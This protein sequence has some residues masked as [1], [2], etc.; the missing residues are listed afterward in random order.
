MFGRKKGGIE[1]SFVDY[2]KCLSDL[3]CEVI[4][5]SYENTPIIHTLPANIQV[6][7]ITNFGQWDPLAAWKLKKMIR[8]LNPD[9]IIAHANRATNLLHKAGI[10]VPIVGVCHKYS[11]NKMLEC[12]YLITVTKDLKTQM[13]KK[14]RQASNI[15][16]VPN[17]VYV[18]SSSTPQEKIWNDPPVIGAMGRFVSLK[19]FHVLISALSI[20]RERNINFRAII[21]GSGVE[22]QNLNNLSKTLG[23]EELISFPGWLDNKDE[24]F[25]TIDLFCVPSL[26]E[27]FGTVILE[28]FMH[29]VPVIA[30][31]TEGL[32]EI[33]QDNV[34]GMIVEAG[35]PDALADAIEKL[36]KN[37]KVADKMAAEG[38]KSLITNYDSKLVGKNIM[39]ILQS[40]IVNFKDKKG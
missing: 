39:E 25:K 32:T 11:N 31:D 26:H 22:Q 40:I 6:K 4:A 28:S 1:Q 7:T 14:G 8:D 36:L 35:E 3:G 20:L 9:I 29:S 12:D 18:P 15:H 10:D 38:Y 30:T 21:A 34:D 5:L 27:T 33:I 16:V 23:V 13:V 37:K 17:M 19:G 24:F 2:S